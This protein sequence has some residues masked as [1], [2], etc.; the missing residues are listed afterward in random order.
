M[1][2]I[3][4]VGKTVSEFLKKALNVK[5]VKVVKVAK[6][7]NSWECEAEVYEESSF[8]KSLGLPTKTQDRN[9]YSVKLDAGLEVESYGRIK[10]GSE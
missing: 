3:E 9:F 7:D 1:A 5:D 10:E 6:I 8:I 4:T 2:N